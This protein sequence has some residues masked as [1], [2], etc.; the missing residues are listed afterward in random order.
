[1]GKD[2]YRKAR[3]LQKQS[4]RSKDRRKVVKEI[5]V[6]IKKKHK[7]GHAP[8]SKPGLD[9]ALQMNLGEM[10][11]DVLIVKDIGSFVT[12]GGVVK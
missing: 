7:E 11:G 2:L 6:E 12:Q 9:L 5:L 10:C 1:M 8:I 3:H 4:T